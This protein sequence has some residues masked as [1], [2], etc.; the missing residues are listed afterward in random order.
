MNS[1]VFE[2]ATRVY[3]GQ[4][5]VR[6]QLAGVLGEF[7]ETVLLAYGGGSIRKNG[8]YQ[9][10]ME[11]LLKAGK[12]VV[13][14]PG[15]MPNPTY[16]KMMEGKKAVQENGVDLILG[17]GGGSVMDCCKAISMAA[18]TDRD[19]WEEFWINR[20]VVDFDPVPVGVVV[21]VVGTGSEV[22]GEGVITHEEQ[23]IKT[24]RHYPRCNPKFAMLDPTYTYSV[25]PMQTAAGGF[26]M[27]SH[28]METYFSEPDEDNISDGISE[29]LMRTIVKN[30]PVAMKEPEN[31]EARSNLMW[32]STMAE[33]GIIKLG[34]KCDFEAHMIEHQMGVYTDCNH[35]MGL[36]VIHPAYYRRICRDGV[37]KFAR[38][39][40]KVWNI[41]PEGRS[42]EELAFAG[43]DALE[44]FIRSLGLPTSLRELGFADRDVL[45]PIADSCILND[46]G[47]RKLTCKEILEILEECW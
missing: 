41:S 26:D 44:A 36:A 24:S 9:E 5:C 46:G 31:Y 34:K 11:A 17:V 22:N 8:I 20:G 40:R 27:L 28:V 45:K 18:A 30:L 1:F 7:G 23:K 14:F 42:E 37:G 13:E 29:T 39:A 38:F 4:G 35:G 2:N 47:Y 32:T 33:I 6:E 43:I 19:V 10:V 15:I 25:P 3:F 16:K 21:T 12:K